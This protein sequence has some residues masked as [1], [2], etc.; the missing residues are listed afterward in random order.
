LKL[1]KLIGGYF[2]SPLALSNLAVHTTPHPSESLKE[3][4]NMELWKKWTIA[5]G[6]VVVGGFGVYSYGIDFIDK[7]C[8]RHRVDREVS[9]MRSGKFDPV[10]LERA[11]IR[12]AVS[13]LQQNNAGQAMCQPTT[14]HGRAL[15]LKRLVT[16]EWNVARRLT[17]VGCV[18]DRA[19][20]GEYTPEQVA[21]AQKMR[22]PWQWGRDLRRQGEENS[23]ARFKS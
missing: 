5:L 13:I 21:E 16:R 12:S 15:A 4:S 18:T 6:V 9:V 23:C 14:A 8:Y 20:A 11:A 19:L 1:K 22:T 17:I 3:G 7:Q 2:Q 10:G